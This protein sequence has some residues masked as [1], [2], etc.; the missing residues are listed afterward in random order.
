MPKVLLD[1]H[2]DAL[3]HSLYLLFEKRL[4][5]EIYR[6]IGEDWYPNYWLV[7]DHPYTVNQFLG[8]QQGKEIPTDVWGKPL[9]EEQRKNLNF[10]VEDGIYYIKNPVYDTVHRA[11]TLEKFKNTHF[12]IILSSV[13]AHIPRFNNLIA[14]FQPHAKHIFQVGNAWGHLPGVKN[15]L[16]S[17]APFAVPSDIN[18]VNYHQEFD[19][20]TFKYEP[21]KFHNVVHSYI[22]YMQSPHLMNSI[23]SSPLLGGWTWMQYGAGMGQSIPDARGMA[24]AYRRSAFTFHFKPEGDGFG[25]TLFSSFACGR[26]PLVWANFYQG[27]AAA[28]LLLD[29]QTCIDASRYP[30]HD[31][32]SL[33]KKFSEPE[34]HLR[35][36]EA[37][38]K[39]FKEVVDFDQEEI[40]I[41]KFLENLQ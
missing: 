41:R 38:H 18:V 27:K 40:K 36:C 10:T 28:P 3:F 29:Q 15:I 4:G 24:D 39:R 8:L 37:A 5:W 14:N 9:P 21:P 17:T 33:L 20:D 19:L 1:Y 13:P 11:I 31:L 30:L 35:M 2:H 7:Y 12:D 23:A 22:H 32:A 26:P 34:E 25:H 16:A 6:Q